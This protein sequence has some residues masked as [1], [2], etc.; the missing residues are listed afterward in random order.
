MKGVDFLGNNGYAL[1]PPS[2]I[3]DSEY[4]SFINFPIREISKEEYSKIT[5][6]F[7][8]E[9]P[10]QMR[11]PFIDILNG[12]I[13][14]EEYATK[15]NNSEFIYWK[16][17]FREA[18]HFCKL[19]PE[20]L[21]SFLKRNQPTFSVEK[22]NYQLN[23][24]YHS[25]R[26]KVLSN[27]RLKEYFPDYNLNSNNSYS[28]NNHNIHKSIDFTL[29]GL[30]SYL[31]E[32]LSGYKYTDHPFDNHAVSRIR[33]KLLNLL[34]HVDK[35]NVKVGDCDSCTA[36]TEIKTVSF[37]DQNGQ[38]FKIREC[39]DCFESDWKMDWDSYIEDL[40]ILHQ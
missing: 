2:K 22:T 16:F 33:T 23:Y 34:F 14:I 39:K 3:G 6:F 36:F 10:I 20:E 35:L 4:T 27:E 7:L 31:S 17:L 1:I 29:N 30:D 5:Q 26:G 15:H 25:Y 12:K 24:N 21:F 32:F 37:R 40:I 9:K 13:E 28:N 19:V 38:L 8:L 11:R 18:Y